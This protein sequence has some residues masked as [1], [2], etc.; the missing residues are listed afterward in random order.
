ME[1]LGFRYGPGFR[2]APL[3]HR[4]YRLAAGSGKG[5]MEVSDP[6]ETP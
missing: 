1:K 4:F 6:E 2:F 3:R 5:I